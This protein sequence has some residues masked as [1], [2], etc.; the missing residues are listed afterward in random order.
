MLNNKI[1]LTSLCIALVGTTGATLSHA[2]SDMGFSALHQSGLYLAVDAGQA[3]ARKYCDNAVDCKSGDMS[4][5]A[6][7]GYQFTPMIGTELGY[8]SFGTLVD[9]QDKNKFDAK[10]DASAW[11]ASVL[12]T[13]PMGEKFGVFGRAGI[14]GY[15]F[16]NSGT[17][18][19]VP[20][21]DDNSTKPYFGVGV[22]FGLNEAWALRAEYQRYTD[23]SGMNGSK[24]SVQG[25]YGGAMYVF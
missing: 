13:W 9:S 6:A 5:R 14:A 19:G 10:Q 23:I 2:A 8:T 3:E 25:W 24:D 17:I 18:Q 20:V 12:A 21:K 22:K 16:T 1:K 4:A 7:V 15:N 11:T